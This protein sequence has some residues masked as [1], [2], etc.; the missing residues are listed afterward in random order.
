GALWSARSYS[1]PLR[2]ALFRPAQTYDTA[3]LQHPIRQRGVSNNGLYLDSTVALDPATGRMAWYF[4]HLPDDQW[5]Y[6][7]AFERQILQL[8]LGGKPT[9][10]V[11]TSGKL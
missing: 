8:P 3:L 1:P 5:D 9:K 7:W 6:D 11:I 10:L 2:L 4:Q